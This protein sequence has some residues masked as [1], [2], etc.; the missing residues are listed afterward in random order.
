MT[1]NLV[2]QDATLITANS[3]N[4]LF[5]LSN[6]KDSRTTKEFRTQTGTTSAQV[7]FDFITTEPVTDV[8]LVGNS[9]QGL[10][11]SGTVTIEAN[12]TNTWGAPAFSTTLTPSELYNFGHTSFTEQNYRFWRISFSN[13]SDFAGL[14]N[15]FI[16]K[17]LMADPFERNINF[18]WSYENR[19]N[20]KFQQNRYNQRFFD[21]INK[22][23]IIK[24]SFSNLS[25]SDYEDLQ[26]AFDLNGIDLPVWVVIDPDELFS[27]DKERFAGQF[28]IN[29]IPVVKNTTFS[30]YELNLSLREAL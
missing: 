10:N 15:I 12:I 14:S 21:K 18:G 23:Q 22:Q 11:L 29:K 30:R 1:F 16:G 5:P 24:A 6:L 17:N 2:N 27:S 4:S 7:V 13:T 28:F 20:T 8:A 9:V 25:K 26:D 3:E 19:A